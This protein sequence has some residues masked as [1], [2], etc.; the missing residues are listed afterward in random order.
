MSFAVNHVQVPCL[1]TNNIFS[2][3]MLEN[4]CKLHSHFLSYYALPRLPVRRLT[5]LLLVGI[6]NNVSIW[7]GKGDF[8][9]VNRINGVPTTRPQCSHFDP[10]RPPDSHLLWGK[11]DIIPI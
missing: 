8:V 4:A 2:F 11:P 10:F 3:K 1:K 9:G 7:Q 6:I 5:F